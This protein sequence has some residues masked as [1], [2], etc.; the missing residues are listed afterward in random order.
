MTQLNINLDMDKLTEQILSSDLNSVTVAHETTLCVRQLKV[1]SS[2]AH[3]T[4]LCVR[5]LKIS[6]SVAH[7]TTLCV[8][9]LRFL[10]SVAH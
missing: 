9:Q 4:T 7:E 1:F 10:G 2:V 8:R 6:V 3:E 5:Q